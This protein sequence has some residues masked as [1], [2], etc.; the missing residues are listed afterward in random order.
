[1]Y[2]LPRVGYLLSTTQFS[3]KELHKLQR[4]AVK[5]FLSAFGYNRHTPNAIV[6]APIEIGG[7]GITHLDSKQGTDKVMYLLTQVRAETMVGDHLR[8]AYNWVQRHAGTSYPILEQ[9]KHPLVY[10][11]NNWITNLRAFLKD[12]GIDSRIPVPLNVT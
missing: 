12:S 6:F 9:T 3:P 4:P 10:L 8:I 5:A 7:V 2:Y 11:E 1:M